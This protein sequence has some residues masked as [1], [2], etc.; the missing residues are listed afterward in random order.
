MNR[1][2][3]KNV[4]KEILRS[5]ERGG[6]CHVEPSTKLALKRAADYKKITL[7]AHVRSIVLQYLEAHPLKR[8]PIIKDENLDLI[9]EL[10]PGAL[11]YTVP[12]AGAKI[13]TTEDHE[14]GGWKGIAFHPDR[15]GT[16]FAWNGEN[17]NLE[18][19]AKTP[20]VVKAFLF[21][22]SRIDDGAAHFS[23]PNTKFII[24]AK[25]DETSRRFAGGQVTNPRTRET[26]DWTRTGWYSAMDP[27]GPFNYLPNVRRILNLVCR[28]TTVGDGGLAPNIPT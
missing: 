21:I 24:T 3:A 19:W 16:T 25:W 5:A 27:S 11:V 9:K 23:I 6:D 12:I 7:S 13:V 2:D 26:Q 28:A 17:L 18:A 20:N 1:D 22:T 4:V 8:P 14:T 10:N 15:L